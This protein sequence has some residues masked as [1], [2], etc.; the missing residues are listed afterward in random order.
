[1]S[2]DTCKLRNSQLRL[3]AMGELL[4]RAAERW[5]SN[6]RDARG[7][8]LI[9]TVA[10]RAGIDQSTLWRIETG[11]LHPNDPMKERLALALNRTV[12]ELFPWPD[13]ALGG[14]TKGSR[15]A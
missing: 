12:V 13:A 7:D 9:A 6:V 11:R 8:E 2:K 15:H 14:Q 5:A 4:E 10:E 3:G 1:M